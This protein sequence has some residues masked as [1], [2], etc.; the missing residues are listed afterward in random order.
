M[1][2]IK[3]L[4]E[5]L[6]EM[7][8][9]EGFPIG[10]DEDILKLSDPPYYTACP[11]PY[12]N[13]FI[14]KHGKPY[15]EETDNYHCEPF[16]GDVSEG[17]ND[18]IYN[19]HSYHTKVPHKA[20]M[21][22]IKHYTDEGDIVFDGFCGTGMTGVAAQMLNRKAILSDLSPIATFIAYNYNKAVDVKEFEKE[23]KRILE[24]VEEECG[25]MYETLHPIK[26]SDCPQG[27]QNV[28]NSSGNSTLRRANAH[29]EVEE[30]V[31]QPNLFGDNAYQSK[32]N[33]N[34]KKYIKAKINYTVWSD[35]FIC[36]YCGEEIIFWDAAVDKEN[37]QVLKEFSCPHCNAEMT[38]RNCKR[39]TKTFFDKTIDKEITQAKQV[40]VMINYTYFKNGKKKRAEK[41]PDAFDLALINKI[42]KMDIPY[43]FP[44]NQMMGEGERW[45]DTW[46][47][48][49]H[50]GITHVHHFYTKRNLWVLSGLG[51]R[52]IGRLKFFF[53][54]LLINNSR[55]GRYG[56][57]T[58]NVSGTLYVPSLIK[59]LNSFEYA[60]R[61][62]WGAKG[63]IK[64]LTN[65][66]IINDE[67]CLSTQSVTA[68]TNLKDNEI[69]YIFTD[70]PFGDNL[71]YSELNFIW[72]SWLKVH[73]NNK[74]EAIMNN[75]QNKGLSEYHQLMAKSFEEYYRVLKPNRWITVEFHNSKSSVWNAI[76]EGMNKAGFIV[77]NV[78]V[79]D[80][81][82]GSFKQVTSS[83]AVKNDLVISAYKPKKEFEDNFLKVVGEGYE[84]EFV[85][86]HLDHQANEPTIERT[87]KMLYSKML[88]YYIQRGYEIAMDS[89]QFYL[90]LRENFVS[91]DNFWFNREQLNHY[92]EYKQK[93][94]LNS[95]DTE[96]STIFSMMIVDEK[97][98][99][100]WLLHFLDEPKDYSTIH[101]AFTKILQT[102]AEDNTPELREILE[103]N[104]V[105][106]DG[107]YRL[108]QTD[109][110][111]TSLSDKRERLLLREFETVLLEAKATRKK[112][113]SIRKE[114]IAHGFNVCY[115][116]SR[117]E[118]IITLAKKLKPSILE[119]DSELNEFVEV[120]EM[121]MEGF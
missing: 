121:K 14:K 86:M 69:D 61:K 66:S 113:T 13:D 30:D 105:F 24:E 114:A 104:F 35:V 70:P 73:T 81:K 53:T 98:A 107:K 117:F 87:E 83:G 1:K 40:P 71:M 16:A 90:M 15:N 118:D 3:P 50:F 92:R 47:K 54:A 51:N 78:A 52:L 74:A 72:E 31:Y 19:A 120:A 82:Q 85:K 60:K 99:I 6:E 108:P 77:A 44:T 49:V 79:L 62:L 36:P 84:A 95:L 89:K 106:A 58:G 102:S 10:K 38:K 101:T 48:G 12:I 7:K 22:Y 56:K 45:G 68:F 94:K 11:N 57:R 34:E 91:Q 59:D 110:E 26:T 4:K 88:A 29:S 9:I 103:A 93:M 111:K 112:N 64:P 32:I 20:I 67:F 23:A 25:W 55:M 8:T 65:L 96:Q 100:I 116:Q 75:V 28:D 2:N 18:P 5:Y 42:D 119:N 97:S 46:R 109:D 27:H 115:R 39:A 33:F 17:K 76:Q 63:F 21:K 37:G 41:T 43:W 80:K